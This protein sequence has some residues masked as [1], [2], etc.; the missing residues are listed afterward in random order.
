MYNLLLKIRYR[1]IIVAFLCLVLGGPLLSLIW[2]IIAPGD[3]FLCQPHWFE[4]VQYTF[5]KVA[6]I[7]LVFSAVSFLASLGKNLA[8]TLAGLIISLI[9]LYIT[10]GFGALNGLALLVQK[11]STSSGETT[12][13]K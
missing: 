9:M 2:A 8:G 6:L 4:V 13:S 11:P 10:V 3:L 7:A 1:G 12:C 5:L